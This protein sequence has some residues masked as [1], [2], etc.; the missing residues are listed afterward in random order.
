MNPTMTQQAITNHHVQAEV[1][2]SVHTLRP[3]YAFSVIGAAWLRMH[4]AHGWANRVCAKH[5]A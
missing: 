3:W 2:S 5:H 1:N 4:N